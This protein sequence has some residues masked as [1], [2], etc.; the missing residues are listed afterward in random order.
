MSARLLAL[1]AFYALVALILLAAAI[2]RRV[3]HALADRR[4]RRAVRSIGHLP[5]VPRSLG[6]ATAYR[7][8][9]RAEREDR[10]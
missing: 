4:A 9:W 2:V 3:S 7:E 1:A 10:L 6:L 8:G 5:L